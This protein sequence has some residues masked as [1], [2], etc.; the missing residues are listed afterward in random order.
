MKSITTTTT[1]SSDVP[2]KWNGTPCEDTRISGSRHTAVTYSAPHSVSRVSTLSM[3]SA[4][5]WPGRMPGMNAPDF[6]RL[7]AVSRA[8]KT[9]AV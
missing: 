3:Y 7:S 4:V 6:F 9:S 8:L 2:P 1:I 5:C